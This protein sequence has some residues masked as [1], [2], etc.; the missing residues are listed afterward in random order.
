MQILLQ[1]G[2]KYHSFLEISYSFS[3]YVFALNDK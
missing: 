1:Y 2:V 3:I